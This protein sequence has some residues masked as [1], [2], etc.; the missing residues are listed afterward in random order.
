MVRARTG[1]IVPDIFWITAIETNAEC[2]ETVNS[3]DGILRKL[4]TQKARV[5]QVATDVGSAPHPCHLAYRSLTSWMSPIRTLRRGGLGWRCKDERSE[6]ERTRKRVERTNAAS[7]ARTLRKPR[8]C[9]TTCDQQWT[10]VTN[11]TV[12]Q[13]SMDV[14]PMSPVLKQALSNSI[15]RGR[16]N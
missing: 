8:K 14:Q 13:T 9:S 16:G 4:V 3:Q 5:W 7:N 15:R 2:E 1:D 10:S 11:S 6:R 12:L